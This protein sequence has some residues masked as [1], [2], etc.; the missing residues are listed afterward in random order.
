MNTTNIF[1]KG[2]YVVACALGALLNEVSDSPANPNQSGNSKFP[3]DGSNVSDV[4][5]QSLISG[6]SYNA[7]SWKG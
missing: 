6:N 1:T 3:G 2:L 7:G 5:N 4:T